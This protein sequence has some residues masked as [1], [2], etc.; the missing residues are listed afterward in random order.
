MTLAEKVG[1]AKCGNKA[2]CYIKQFAQHPGAHARGSGPG[3]GAPLAD[4]LSTHVPRRRKLRLC[5]LLGPLG[6][7][8][9]PHPGSESRLGQSWA[10]AA[11][12]L[13]VTE[14]ELFPQPPPKAFD[15]VEVRRV[16]RDVDQADAPL[17][18]EASALPGVQ[19][20]LIVA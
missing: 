2:S 20:S 12:V 17:R 10:T 1:H 13:K 18:V 14:P 7:Q 11:Q 19:E 3:G 8:E 4:D 15:R 16:T 9:G 6:T 5:D